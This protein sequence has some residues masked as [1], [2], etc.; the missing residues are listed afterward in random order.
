MA[1]KR[2]IKSWASVDF[3]VFLK[4]SK[5]K[6][7]R[8]GGSTGKCNSFVFGNATIDRWVVNNLVNWPVS[9]VFK[10]WPVN[11]QPE[12]VTKS[13]KK[14]L[15]VT[16][17]CCELGIPSQNV[18]KSF[19]YYLPI[20]KWSVNRCQSFSATQK[21]WVLCLAG[22]S[23]GVGGV[24]SSWSGTQRQRWAYAPFFDPWLHMGW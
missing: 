22:R 7:K 16:S 3:D 11:G 17:R 6:V 24:S 18:T 10:W 23:G 21:K 14:W 4:I 12:K 9:W 15:L 1:G 5:P 13:K 20:P 8:C 19:V 2:S